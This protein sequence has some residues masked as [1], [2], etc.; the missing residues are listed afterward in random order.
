MK[1][2]KTPANRHKFYTLLMLVPF[3]LCVLYYAAFFGFVLG[4]KAHYMHPSEY[5]TYVDVGRKAQQPHNADLLVL[6]DSRAKA[7]FVPQNA[8][9]LNLA[10]G[11]TTAIESYYTFKRYLVRNKPPKV[12]ILSYMSV[13]FRGA[14]T[15]WERAVKFDF[16][17][18]NEFKEVAQNAKKLGECGVLGK[19][20][21]ADFIKYKADIKNFS[22]EIYNAWQEFKGGN[23]RYKRYLQVMDELDKNGGHY[24]YGRNLGA[25]DDNYEVS[26]SDFKANAL[27]LL[28]VRKIAEL[29]AMNGMQVFHY[30]MPFNQSSFDKLNAGFVRDYNGFLASLQSLGI[31]PLN[32]IWGLPDSDFGDP[33]HLYR[34]AE[35]TTRDILEKIKF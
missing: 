34:G 29:A 26:Q 28:Y 20:E 33:S 25:S 5:P 3:G 24:F 8:K 11:G 30:Q 12:L 31:K 22:A 27:I 23:P 21:V 13:H 35:K 14:D 4:A 2:T 32:F 15:F 7:G 19:C 10:I 1:F 17:K 16:L 9:Q 18:F 6:G